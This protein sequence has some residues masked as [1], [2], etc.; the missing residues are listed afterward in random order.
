MALSISIL[1]YELR[2]HLFDRLLPLP[3]FPFSPLAS[4]GDIF[5]SL[6]NVVLVA[7][8]N[9]NYRSHSHLQRSGLIVSS[10]LKY[11]RSCPFCRSLPVQS[12]AILFLFNKS[13]LELRKNSGK[14]RLPQIQFR[15]DVWLV[16]MEWLLSRLAIKMLR[17]QM[18]MG[19]KN[20]LHP[21]QTLIPCMKDYEDQPVIRQESSKNLV[22]KCRN[23][24]AIS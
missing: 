13:K 22:T 5:S 21:R 11:W 1:Q 17:I 19:V 12:S 2:L 3:F 10:V 4:K 24:I 9:K 7:N 6:E 18:Q 8:V 23:Y 16:S 20:T 15:L 14:K